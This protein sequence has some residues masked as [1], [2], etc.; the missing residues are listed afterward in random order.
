MPTIPNGQWST[1]PNNVID[2]VGYNQFVQCQ[3]VSGRVLS[4]ELLQMLPYKIVAC[5]IKK[6]EHAIEYG[7]RAKDPYSY[8]L[9]ILMERFCYEGGGAVIAESRNDRLD[10]A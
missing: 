8:S 1:A 6:R 9:H 5:A 7:W 4:A 3:T 2:L 10:A